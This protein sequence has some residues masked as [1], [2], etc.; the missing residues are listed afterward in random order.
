MVRMP[1]SRTTL[2]DTARQF[3]AGLNMVSVASVDEDGSPRQAVAWYRLEPDDRILLNSRLP[4][5]WCANL[6]RDPHV[7]L[8]VIDMTDGYRWIGLSGVVDEV[9]EDV[10]RARD[11]IVA[12]AHRYHPEGPSASSIATFRR[13]PRVSLLVRITGVHDHLEDD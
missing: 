6:L 8:A 13:Q 9:V 11:D 2:T 10:D 1:V 7:S 12:L 3:L 4:R 5:R